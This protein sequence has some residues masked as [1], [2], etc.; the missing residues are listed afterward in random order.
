MTLLKGEGGGSDDTDVDEPTLPRVYTKEKKKGIDIKQ[1]KNEAK[2]KVDWSQHTRWREK[3]T[4]KTVCVC[5]W[6][7]CTL[8]EGVKVGRGEAT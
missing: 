5:V 7:V 4:K 2:T 3:K 8:D 6:R 1:R